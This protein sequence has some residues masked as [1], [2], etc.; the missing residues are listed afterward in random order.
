VRTTIGDLD[1]LSRPI[2]YTVMLWFKPQDV[3]FW[4][5]R[6]SSVF[7][8][9]N[10]LQCYFTSLGSVMCDSVKNCDKLMAMDVA[11]QV[12][13]N[14]WAHITVSGRMSS[15]YLFKGESYLTIETNTKGIVSE[16]S[17]DY[18]VLQ[19]VKRPFSVC[20]GGCDS[21]YTFIGGLRDFVV[22]SK[23]TPK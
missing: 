16:D 4:G 7:E 20:L 14:E 11:K 3:A 8:F 13:V 6:Y 5:Q 15:P 19:Q 12:Q 1:T 2:D 23:Y 10:S 18:L 22:L 21:R 9:E 17:R